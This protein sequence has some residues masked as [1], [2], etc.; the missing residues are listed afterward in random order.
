MLIQHATPLLFFLIT[1][2]NPG[3]FAN[4]SCLSTTYYGS[5]STWSVFRPD[6]AFIDSLSP[7]LKTA[8]LV[9]TSNPIQQLVWVEEIAVHEY[10]KSLS[11]DDDFAV[12][13]ERLSTE[14]LYNE[15]YDQDVLSVPRPQS[16]FDVLYRTPT[17][18]LLSLPP[19]KALSLSA[20]LPPFYKSIPLPSYPVPYVPV[21]A[22]AIE[23]VKYL[24]S[25]LKFNPDVASVVSNISI[26]QMKQDIRFLTGEDESSDIISRHSFTE[27]SIIAANWLKEQFEGTGAECR[28]ERFMEGFSPNVVW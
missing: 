16:S 1:P 25:A 18:A 23:R 4:D 17:T 11:R 10:L 12:F 9:Y 13:L 7:T 6:V 3:L 24:L 14:A 5:Y 26:P 15:N 20:F 8:S 22:S 21:P 27:G 2:F 19:A 28:L